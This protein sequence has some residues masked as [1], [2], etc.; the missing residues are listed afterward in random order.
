MINFI[1]INDTTHI[2]IQGISSIRAD[3]N[4]IFNPDDPATPQPGSRPTLTVYETYG[5]D[6][7]VPDDGL[8]GYYQG[9]IDLLRTTYGYSRYSAGNYIP[10]YINP[11]KN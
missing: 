4:V 1:Q 11:G 3:H 5:G 7:A 2:G 6:H 9:V 10:N 8:T